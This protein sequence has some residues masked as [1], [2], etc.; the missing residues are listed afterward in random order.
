MFWHRST[1]VKL[2]PGARVLNRHGHAGTVTQEADE[3]GECRVIF[4]F[5]R[6]P[7]PRAIL[8]AELTPMRPQL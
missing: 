7:Q 1:E 3:H 4:D 2:S 6:F 5:Q 8:A